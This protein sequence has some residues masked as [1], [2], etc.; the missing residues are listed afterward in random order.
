MPDILIGILSGVCLLVL[1]GA[2]FLLGITIR[3]QRRLK[4][5]ITIIPLKTNKFFYW[6][7]DILLALLFCG[8]V[9]LFIN[10]S[11]QNV[12][13]LTKELFTVWNLNTAEVR[14]VLAL[15][16]VINLTVLAV[17][18]VLTY[19]KSAV[20]NDGIYTAIYFLD[21]NHLY[22]FYFE[23]K[24]NKV[25]VSNNRNGALTLSGTSSPLKFNPAD[26]EKLKFL[27]NKNKNKFVS[28]N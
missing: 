17:S 3:H 21:W 15:L 13:P 25:I 9:Y 6:L 4:Y 2:G 11:D 19:A 12:Y 24:G 14:I 16:M 20:V 18:A 26:R 1:A 22:D 5:S 23:K 8:L 10:P 27:L 28:K 7:L